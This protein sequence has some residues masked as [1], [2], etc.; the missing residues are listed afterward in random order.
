MK[1]IPFLKA[2]FVASAFNVTSF[3]KFSLP[4]IAIAGKS[5]VGKSSLINHL[6]GGR[7]AKTSSTPGK[8]QSINFFK[9]DE[10]LS[11]VDLPGYGYAKV[12]KAMKADWMENIDTYFENRKKLGLILLLIDIRRLPS[13]DDLAFIRWLAHHEK[14]FL[15]VFTK[16]DKVKGHE[17]EA[18][19]KKA[20]ELLGTVP[21]L[22]YS[23]KDPKSKLQL[24]EAITYGLS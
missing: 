17:K 2:E 20:L 8:T 23:I 3:P 4:E 15:V 10:M 9:V 1:K 14:N 13:D 12:T 19:T 16:T 11:L 24:A 21:Y 5:N 7:F 18:N 22:Y 6:L